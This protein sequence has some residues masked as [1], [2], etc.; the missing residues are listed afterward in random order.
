MSPA[1]TNLEI[2]RKP[3]YGLSQVSK[4]L[5]I[6]MDVSIPADIIFI[7]SSLLRSYN[8]NNGKRVGSTL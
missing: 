2:Y 1:P 3:S 8:A 7:L 5:V 6:A 4:M